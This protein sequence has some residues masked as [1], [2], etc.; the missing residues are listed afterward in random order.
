MAFRN[1][2]PRYCSFDIMY[3]MPTICVES[4]SFVLMAAAIRVM[5]SDRATPASTSS[6]RLSCI[7][8][9]DLAACGLRHVGARNL[10]FQNSGSAIGLCQLRSTR[11]TNPFLP[12]T[13]AL[14]PRDVKTRISA[15][16][17]IE[18]G[19]AVRA[20]ATSDSWSL[21]KYRSSGAML[22]YGSTLFCR[23]SGSVALPDSWPAT[24]PAK[25][26]SSKITLAADLSDRA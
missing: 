21:I 19:A 3:D 20:S 17:E 7:G 23:L 11:Q 16:F 18:G 1:R 14:Y 6:V 26:V 10:G 13:A 24:V 4:N 25:T 5:I 2:S 22:L 15:S 8:R 12:L 9:T